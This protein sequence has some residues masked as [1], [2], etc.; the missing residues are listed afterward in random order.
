[1]LLFLKKYSSLIIS[2]LILGNVIIEVLCYLNSSI[3]ERLSY[4]LEFTL[5][6]LPIL[7]L[8]LTVAIKVKKR[9]CF[10]WAQ[11]FSAFSFYLMSFLI[12]TTSF[13][14]ENNMH[15]SNLS[16]VQELWLFLFLPLLWLSP[17]WIGVGILNYVL[18][19]RIQHQKN[20]RC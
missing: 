1:M 9:Y 20:K 5:L 19:S 18:I 16:G 3:I 7:W 2:N 10:L 6:I 8:F 13:L 14:L 15:F 4:H 17:I 12:I 11:I